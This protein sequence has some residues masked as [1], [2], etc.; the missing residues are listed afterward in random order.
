[1]RHVVVVLLL[2]L[3]AAV[4]DCWCRNM[5]I[6]VRLVTADKCCCV[7]I[8]KQTLYYE[9]C[10]YSC[11]YPDTDTLWHS[12]KICTTISTKAWESTDLKI[13]L[14]WKANDSGWFLG[15]VSSLYFPSQP[16][17]ST[18]ERFICGMLLSVVESFLCT[19]PVGGWFTTIQ[20][21][22]PPSHSISL[23]ANSFIVTIPINI[24]PHQLR[25]APASLWFLVTN[26]WLLIAI[27]SPQRQH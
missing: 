27:T 22:H 5:D 25:S 11:R 18:M 10:R 8:Q 14:A 7:S 9:L 2:L 12:L 20:S 16:S 3:L 24:N 19:V 26:D 6:Y 15:I 13:L 23:P 21:H 17:I 1:M 4:V